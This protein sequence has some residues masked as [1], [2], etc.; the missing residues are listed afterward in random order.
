[1]E[2][3]GIDWRTILKLILKKWGGESWLGFFWLRI[4]TGGVCL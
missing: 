3:I 2:D 1:L 4:G